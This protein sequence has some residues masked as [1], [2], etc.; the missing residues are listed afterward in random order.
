MKRRTPI[1]AL[2]AV[3]GPLLVVACSAK[4][5]PVA[6]REA[7]P[8]VAAAS[9]SP[10]VVSPPAPAVG[11]EPTALAPVRISVEEMNRKGYVKDAFFDYDRYDLRPDQRDTL[12]KD[13]A[14]LREHPTVK[15]MVEGHCDERGTSQYNMALG[16]QRAEAVK[17]YLVQLG[18]DASRI[19]IISYGKERPFEMGHDEKAWAQNRRDH[20]LVTAS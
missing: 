10:T 17:D 15:I 18:I 19:Q 7:K 14:W 5:K 16:Q 20:F 3:A 13:A 6:A 12:T 8:I 9:P 11:M 1:I 2:L 4:P